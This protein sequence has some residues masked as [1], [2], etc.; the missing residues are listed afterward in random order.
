MGLLTGNIA[1]GARLKLGSAGLESHFAMGSYGSDSEDRDELPAVALVRA[2][3]TWGVEF[4]PGDVVVVG[5]TPRD[6]TCGQVVGARTVAVATGH[7]DA[8]ALADAGADSVL[9]DLSETRRVV[10]ILLG[11]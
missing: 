11:E 10:E 1:Q 9:E 3:E 6:V 4:D 7:F 5:D 8:R 2:R